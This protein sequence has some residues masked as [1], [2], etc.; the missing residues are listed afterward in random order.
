[1]ERSGAEQ[2]SGKRKRLGSQIV[3]SFVQSKHSTLLSRPEARVNMRVTHTRT[4]T[5]N[6]FLLFFFFRFEP[7]SLTIKDLIH[8]YVYN[9]VATNLTVAITVQTSQL[10]NND[11]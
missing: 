7:Q 3:R 6:F 8:T 2:R 9:M 10:I 1:M 11:N 4:A 5:L